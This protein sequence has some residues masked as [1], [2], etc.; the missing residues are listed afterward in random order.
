MG[1]TKAHFCAFYK[2]TYYY[3]PLEH[4]AVLIPSLGVRERSTV[5]GSLSCLV[6]HE[7]PWKLESCCSAYR[8]HVC[9]PL[10]L[11]MWRP[12]DNCGFHSSGVVRIDFSLKGSLAWL[13][14]GCAGCTDCSMSPSGPSDFLP[15]AEIASPHTVTAGSCECG[16]WEVK[17][18]SSCMQN[19]HF[20]ETQ[21]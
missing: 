2:A 10:C 5:Q 7:I 13:S 16:F 14:I 1:E 18:G 8:T 19:W 6:L 21:S 20:P 3:N 12:E 15:S 17:L 11:C 4:A 9:T